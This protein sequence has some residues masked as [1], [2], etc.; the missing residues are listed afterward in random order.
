MQPVFG[1][2]ACV[3]AARVGSQLLHEVG[4]RRHRS[5]SERAVYN[6]AM[7]TRIKGD[8]DRLLSPWSAEEELAAREPRA[9]G[10]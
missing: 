2:D 8:M 4:I 3:L 9:A 10:R 5:R 7:A 6:Q 1:K